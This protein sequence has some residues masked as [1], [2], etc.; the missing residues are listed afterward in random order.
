M[1]TEW[2]IIAESFDETRQ[3]PWQECLDFIATCSGTG[4]DIGCGNGRHLIPLARRCDRVIGLDSASAMA[5]IA[6][7]N[8]R[9]ACLDNAAIMVANAARLPLVD[10]AADCILFIASLHNIPGRGRRVAALC[11]LRRVLRPG[12]KALLSVWSKWQ[13]RWRRKSLQQLFMPGRKAG[14]VMVPWKKDD[15]DVQRFYHLYGRR[16]LQRDIRQAG[17]YVSMLWSVKKA[18]KRYPDNHFAVV[19]KKAIAPARK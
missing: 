12:G 19:T 15:M 1:A 7:K 5:G 10:N 3:H 13:D 6:R 11:E 18:S 2:D 8:L 16:E 4:V 14:D 9:Q 17:L